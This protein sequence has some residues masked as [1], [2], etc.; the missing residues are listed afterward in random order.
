M[1][2]ILTR[3]ATARAPQPRRSA[4]LALAGAFVQLRP[5][6]GVPPVRVASA[7]LR[8]G[9]TPIELVTTDGGSPGFTFLSLHENE[10]TAVTAARSFVERRGGRL[11]ELR[12]LG[13]RLLSFSLKQIRYRV[14]PNRIFTDAGIEK[15]LRLY[16]RFSA[17]AHDAVVRFRNEILANILGDHPRLIVAVHNNADGGL[18][19]TE[20]YRQGGPLQRE[21]A[22]MASNP[23]LNAHDF[24]L[25]SD[26][27][28]FQR[29]QAAGFNVVLQSL[30]PADDGSLS[31]YCQ[32]RRIPYAN[33][34]A[35]QGHLEEQSRMLDALIRILEPGRL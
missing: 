14:D 15:S 13:Q 29:F 11:I 16:G 26:A 20:S 1:Q 19:T 35:E 4:L 31:V 28:L 33:V 25:V 18:S 7:K 6:A 23:K 30:T 24:F 34:E 3:S 12:Q 10:Q 9:D 2:R 22:R 5:A 32:Q 21:A 8:L 17:P 27:F